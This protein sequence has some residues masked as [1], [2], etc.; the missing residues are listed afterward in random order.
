[1]GQWPMFPGMMPQQIPQ[2]PPL[3]AGGSS[4]SGTVVRE[5]S[6]VASASRRD[7]ESPRLS[8]P[9]PGRHSPS[10]L[11]SSIK[12]KRKSDVVEYD[13][14]EEKTDTED[15]E[16]GDEPPLA[17]LT[18]KKKKTERKQKQKEKEERTAKRTSLPY[19][20]PARNPHENQSQ[21][22]RL[23]TGAT[24][25]GRL[26]VNAD[27]KPMQFFV[28]VDLKDRLEVTRAIKVRSL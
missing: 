5:G 16:D 6:S 9:L 27:E 2:I 15:D 22:S 17:S 19:A 4:G 25:A 11:H 21:A 10:V 14:A 12:R 28:Q 1:M 13:S 3:S 8:A 18:K 20:A 7:T 26:F 23:S 24:S